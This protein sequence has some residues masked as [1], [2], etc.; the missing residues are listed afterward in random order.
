VLLR[1][2]PAN[3]SRISDVYIMS[4]DGSGLTKLTDGTSYSR[5]PSWSPSGKEVVFTSDRAG[6]SQVLTMKSD[7][8]DVRVLVDGPGTLSAPR[9]SPDGKLVFYSGELEHET[10]IFSV[11]TGR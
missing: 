3:E 5:Y 10:K 11:E 4:T 1:R 2:K 9:F 6:H 7:G 8:T